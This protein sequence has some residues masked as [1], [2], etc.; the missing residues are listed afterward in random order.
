MKT[1]PTTINE[2]VF[3]TRLFFVVFPNMS[4]E[5]VKDGRSSPAKISMTPHFFHGFPELKRAARSWRQKLKRGCMPAAARPI[6][7]LVASCISVA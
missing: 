2:H 7:L 6:D 3:I 4:A 1:A 5:R